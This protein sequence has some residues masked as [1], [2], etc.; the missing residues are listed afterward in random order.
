MDLHGVIGWTQG[1]RQVLIGFDDDGYLL[2]VDSAVL[3]LNGMVL[4]RL[5]VSGSGRRN[6]LSHLL[7]RFS[8]VSR[9]VEWTME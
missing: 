6:G 7:G 1:F 5:E 2:K 3:H 8:V 9:K 4:N